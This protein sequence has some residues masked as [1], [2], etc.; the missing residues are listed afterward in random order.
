MAYYGFPQY[1]SVAEK[2][3]KAQKSL[4]KLR[5]KNPEIAPVII[6]GR[7]LARTWWGKAWN[8]NLESY[9]DYANR[10]GRGRSYVRRGAVLDLRI[11]PGKVAALVQGSSA[12]P[13]RVEIT[14]QPLS[15]RNWLAITSACE[16]KIDSLPELLAGKFPKALAEL[17]TVQGKG[18]FP[19]PKEISLSCS[20]PDW[21]TM[22]K[23]VAAV[24]YGVGVRL[25]EDP[26]LFFVLRNLKVE[27]LVT[28][29]IVRK[30]ETLLKKSGR[31]S[32][33]IIDNGDLA[34]MFGI[35]MET[36]DKE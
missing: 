30:S 31:K 24:L 32:G 9:S 5:K 8:D 12:K 16:G 4:E 33:R 21:A 23:H 22:C 19:A 25:D 1:V 13:Y 36:E 35:E 11:A 18:L 29:A 27:E 26:A 20:C 34:G 15:K 6:E 3:A 17:F 10:L 2:R 14:V 28:Q 7:K